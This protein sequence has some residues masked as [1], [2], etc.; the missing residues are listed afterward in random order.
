[1]EATPSNLVMARMKEVV[2]GLIISHTTIC[3][4]GIIVETGKVV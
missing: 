4:L 1:M 3:F 2:Q